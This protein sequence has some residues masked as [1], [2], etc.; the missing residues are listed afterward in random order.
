MIKMNSFSECL[1][2]GI[3]SNFSDNEIFTFSEYYDNLHSNLNIK[4][5]TSDEIHEIKSVY[6]GFLFQEIEYKFSYIKNKISFSMF[7]TYT[8]NEWSIFLDH[9]FVQE[10]H[11]ILLFKI[12]KSNNL[13][14]LKKY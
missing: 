6:T 5:Y 9:R 4:F 1:I 12:V 2:K 7:F 11:P 8:E 3:L 13:Y 14:H 10:Y